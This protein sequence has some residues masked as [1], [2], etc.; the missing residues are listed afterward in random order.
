MFLSSPVSLLLTS[1]SSSVSLLSTQSILI[2]REVNNNKETITVIMISYKV[3]LICFFS[4][5][6]L[7]SAQANIISSS[8]ILSGGNNIS[9]SVSSRQETTSQVDNTKHKSP[10][11]LRV[12]R[13]E[14]N[15]TESIRF[16]IIDDESTSAPS[17][18]QLSSLKNLL[19]RSSPQDCCPKWKN[20]TQNQEILDELKRKFG[21]KQKTSVALKG[22][23]LLSELSVTFANITYLSIDGQ[24]GENERD[25]YYSYYDNVHYFLRLIK[26]AYD[27]LA[28]EI[29]N[30]DQAVVA[31]IATSPNEID[32][33]RKF[34]RRLKSLL[35]KAN[36]DPI[37]SSFIHELTSTTASNSS[38]YNHNFD[39]YEDFL[40]KTQFGQYYAKNISVI[41]ESVVVF[42]QICS[43]L[44][45]I[46]LLGNLTRPSKQYEL[47]RRMSFELYQIRNELIEQISLR[48]L[49]NR[50]DV[51]RI[52]ARLHDFTET[53]PYIRM[54]GDEFSSNPPNYRVYVRQMTQL[55]DLYLRDNMTQASF[56][57]SLS[58]L[59][60]DFILLGSSIA[61]Y[62]ETKEAPQF[63]KF[64]PLPSQGKH[65]PAQNQTVLSD[66]RN[67]RAGGWWTHIGLT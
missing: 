60:E 21:P 45:H 14:F 47:I 28:R 2:V 8:I 20:L 11:K 25:K 17:K 48:V 67:I 3:I 55:L 56:Y 15:S 29:R 53:R 6:S 41:R 7:A 18:Q 66:K 61:H 33:T 50:H 9:S 12:P 63:S 19:L 34:Q 44:S 59:P 39:F 51:Q 58:E 54:L 32:F 23:D 40:T 1:S 13:D 16:N 27:F 30:N 49:S 52:F 26:V 31:T 64:Y 24:P 43:H 4:Q 36:H 37:L 65:Q 35:F 10:I 38:S 22:S 62:Y 5:V 42:D 46:D 57:N